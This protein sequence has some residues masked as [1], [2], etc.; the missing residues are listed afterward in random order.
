MSPRTRSGKPCASQRRRPPRH[1]RPRHRWGR[2]WGVGWIWKVICGVPKI[3]VSPN[4]PK[5]R[6]F[7]IEP[8][9]FGNPPFFFW[10][11]NFPYITMWGSL[12]LCC[13]HRPRL[14]PPSLS[15]YK[16]L[17]RKH[18]LKKRL[19]TFLDFSRFGSNSPNW[20]RGSKSYLDVPRLFACQI[21]FRNFWPGQNTCARQTHGTNRK[22]PENILA[23]SENA[24]D[25]QWW[26]RLLP[27]CSQQQIVG[28]LSW[29]FKRLSNPPV[30]VGYSFSLSNFSLSSFF[31]SRLFLP[32]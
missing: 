31:V 32:L 14:P 16:P 21:R 5:I 25:Q 15:T 26:V 9:G 8:Y 28:P 12:F 29:S 4:H 27:Q 7:S 22:H 11:F 20:G 6:C 18:A 2:G 24:E 30:S 23:P 19:P 17:C 3:G 13:I 10:K 1:G